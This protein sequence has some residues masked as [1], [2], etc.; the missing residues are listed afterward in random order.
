MV[1]SL[2]V[3]E[4]IDR[5]SKLYSVASS[6][7]R[8]V[9][10]SDTPARFIGGSGEHLV[11]AALGGVIQ[12]MDS[13]V[14]GLKINPAFEVYVNGP[15]G[16]GRQHRE[17]EIERCTAWTTTT[18]AA[19]RQVAAPFGAGVQADG[20]PDS[21]VMDSEILWDAWHFSLCDDACTIHTHIIN[22]TVSNG[23][24]AR[25]TRGGLELPTVTLPSED[26]NKGLAPFVIAT[27]YPGGAAVLLTAL[28]RTQPDPIGWVEPKAH[29]NLTV[30]AASASAKPS[31]GELPVVGILG[32]FASV[33]LH[34]AAAPTNA[35]Q[36]R[37]VKARDMVG[38]TSSFEQLA[39]PEAVW[40]DAATLRLD[41]AALARVGTAA[42][43]RADDVSAPGVVLQLG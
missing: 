36:A 11:T 10:D 20:K 33:T 34:F 23:A 43:S 15:P 24:P 38:E 42:K 19:G 12:P 26:S 21:V 25:V 2:S 22:K 4:V 41:G 39:A 18:D 1:K 28:G 31:G 13:N 29:V 5:Q 37:E 30:P 3:V 17:D 27:R 35:D 40:L 32:R 6:L 8:A 16:R 14:R 7:P 9:P